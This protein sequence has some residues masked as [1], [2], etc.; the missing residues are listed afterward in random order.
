MDL[1]FFNAF[2]NGDVH[3][4]RSFVKEI[5]SFNKFDKYYYI[6]NHHKNLI[7]DIENLIHTPLS[8]AKIPVE[9]LDT[10]N[11]LSRQIISKHKDY[12]VI[13]TWYETQLDYSSEYDGVKFKTLYKN[14]SHIYKELGMS[15]SKNAFDYF[16]RIDY[17]H[18]DTSSAEKWL[19]ETSS[20][21]KILFCNENG[22][23][24]QTNNYDLSY[25]IHDLAHVFPSVSFLVSNKDNYK[26]AHL[27][28][29]YFAEDVIGKSNNLN[30][31]SF[32]ST[33]CDIIFGRNS[34]A[35]TFTIV[36]ENVNK[37]N[38]SNWKPS[39]HFA[40]EFSEYQDIFTIL[41]EE[42]IAILHCVKYFINKSLSEK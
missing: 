31:L 23:S 3:A 9:R 30:E 40:A 5:V 4:S 15:M 27:K 20:D 8:T 1:Y 19:R 25:V 13:N 33:K 37:T 34:G 18:Y 11:P 35:H 24:T 21:L 29:I 38:I 16:P 36:K 6:H 10:S 17:K 7:G 41:T 22:N 26:L 12:T 39:L 28:N 32:L 14:F 2:G 42:P